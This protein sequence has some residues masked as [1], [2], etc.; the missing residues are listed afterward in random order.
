MSKFHKSDGSFNP[1]KRKHTQFF[2]AAFLPRA[3]VITPEKDL[4]IA[5]L[6]RAYE[7]YFEWKQK[8]EEAKKKPRNNSGKGPQPGDRYE[9][10]LFKLKAWF[11]SEEMHPWSFLWLCQM[12][13]EGQSS[14]LANWFRKAITEPY[15]TTFH[16]S[17]Y[18]PRLPVK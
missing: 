5:V 8:V 2:E 17:R 4:V 13:E 6:C 1:A 15:K 16:S 9:S 18:N 14:F 3:A 12:F 11:D 10:N 7:D